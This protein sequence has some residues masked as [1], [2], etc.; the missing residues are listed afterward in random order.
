MSRISVSAEPLLELLGVTFT[1]SSTSADLVLDSAK[2]AVEAARIL[3]G[4]ELLNIL[5]NGHVSEAAQTEVHV[6][7]DNNRVAELSNNGIPVVLHELPL[8]RTADDVVSHRSTEDVHVSGRNGIGRRR[9]VKVEGNDVLGEQLGILGSTK[10]AKRKKLAVD[11]FGVEP[12]LLED[13]DST[14]GLLDDG[15]APDSH[16]ERSRNGVGLGVLNPSVETLQGLL[17]NTIHVSTA[18]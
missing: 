13:F 8:H 11:R 10:N 18:I 12:L 9:L 5:D 2:S 6:S 7:I 17:S 3:V 14:G 16:P 15:G 1:V 4:H